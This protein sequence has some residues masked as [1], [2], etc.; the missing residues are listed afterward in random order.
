MT[1]QASPPITLQNIQDEFLQPRGTPL[2]SFYRGA[3]I[4]PNS[5]QN[6]GVPTSGPISLLD[7]LGA[8]RQSIALTNETVEAELAAGTA[9]AGYRINSGG[10]VD[11][12]RNG[13]ATGEGTWLLG[14]SAGDFEV[15][16]NVTSG[17]LSSGT[18]GSWVNLGSTQTWTR[19]RTGPG[20]ATCI[21][22]VTIRDVAT[23]TTQATATVT[24][25][26]TVG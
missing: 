7:F 1:L 5:P 13:A 10:T 14:G 24:L 21:F 2:S 16:I 23:Q 15:F 26:A 25:T 6:A 17:S 12:L 18:A 4:V 11:T 20:V 19:A 9:T 8:S 22:T 3:G